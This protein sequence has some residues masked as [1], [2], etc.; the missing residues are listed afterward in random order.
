MKKQSITQGRVCAKCGGGQ[1]QRLGGLGAYGTML[2]AYLED[3]GKLKV[4]TSIYLH[5]RCAFSLKGSL[6]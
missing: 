3:G 5:V 1:S 2:K 6:S 4:P